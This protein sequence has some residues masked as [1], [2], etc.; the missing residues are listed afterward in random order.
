MKTRTWKD[1]KELADAM[2]GRAY[3]GRTV[4]LS[5][6]TAAWLARQLHNAIAFQ[7]RP[8]PTR[9]SIH[10]VNLYSEGSRVYQLDHNGEDASIVAWARNSGVALAALEE[11]RKREPN[12]RFMQRRRGWVE[13]K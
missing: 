7:N 10:D 11:L 1:A 2:Q 6:E 5:P 12:T 9:K 4:T 13:W 3:A 8:A